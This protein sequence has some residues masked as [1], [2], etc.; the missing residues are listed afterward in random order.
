MT[1]QFVY[2]PGRPGEMLGLFLCGVLE[3]LLH[4]GIAR[5]QCLPLVQSLGADLAAVIDAHQCGGIFLLGL[6]HACFGNACVGVG[7]CA[8]RLVA[9]AWRTV[10]AGPAST[11]SRWQKRF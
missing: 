6:I 9:T 2:A 3:S 5:G 1:A 10:D 11:V 7:A 8:M 4:A